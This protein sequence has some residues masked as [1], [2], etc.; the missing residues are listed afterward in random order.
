LIA[1]TN[2]QQIV[3]AIVDLLKQIDGNAPYSSNLFNNIEPRLV[4]WDAVNDFPFVCVTAGDETREYL[5]SGFKWGYVAITIRV[6]VREDNA[7][8]ALEAIMADIEYVIDGN[9][10]FNYDNGNKSVTDTRVLSIS[11]DEGVME[12]LGIG[13]I[14]LQCRYEP[15]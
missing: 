2:R 14:T 10:Q 3:Q 5:P 7:M 13:E 4:W 12:P 6:Y 15:Q 9:F 11:T 8:S 1:R